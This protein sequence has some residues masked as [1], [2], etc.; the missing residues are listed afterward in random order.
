MFVEIFNKHLKESVEFKEI[1][2]FWTT[3]IKVL[4]FLLLSLFSLPA[5]TSVE[6]LKFEPS[7]HH[8][9]DEYQGQIKVIGEYS[10]CFTEYHV[11][12]F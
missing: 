4:H 1:K 11:I 5:I 2:I 10:Y 9:F 12:Y 3:Q 8:Y 6:G 7:T